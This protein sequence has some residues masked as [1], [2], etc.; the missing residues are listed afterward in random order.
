MLWVPETPGSYDSTKEQSERA[1]DAHRKP[2]SVLIEPFI[3]G[4]KRTFLSCFR[5]LL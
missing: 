4:F 3:I 2:V 1:E 5:N